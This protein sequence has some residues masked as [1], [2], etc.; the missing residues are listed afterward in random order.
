M[1]YTSKDNLILKTDR[2]TLAQLVDDTGSEITTLAQAD[3]S[4]DL[5]GSIAVLDAFIADADVV[6]NG[7]VLGKAD[8]TDATVI[9][10]LEVHAS[11]IV[12]YELFRRRY[13][14]DA[15]S[16]PY[17]TSYRETKVYL[18]DVADGVKLITAAPQITSRV[19]KNTSGERKFSSD[20]LEHF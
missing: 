19:K 8:L 15:E 20:A 11:R 1:A 16:N 9:A 17:S 14:D 10:N 3:T 5:S 4:L 18:Q 6:I 2:K 7:Y 13:A 12:L